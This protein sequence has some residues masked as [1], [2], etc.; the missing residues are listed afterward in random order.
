[1]IIEWIIIPN[2]M[3][4]CRHDERRLWSMGGK[5][6]ILKGLD[7]YKYNNDGITSMLLFVSVMN[8]I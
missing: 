6:M 1:M 5:I 8:I 2:D 7:K 3:Y 4:V